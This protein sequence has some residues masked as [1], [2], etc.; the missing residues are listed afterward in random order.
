MLAAAFENWIRTLRE[1]DFDDTFLELLRAAGFYDLHFTHGQ[2][3]FGKD[4]IAKLRGAP[5]VQYAF[6]SKA[7]D[8]GGSDW[9]RRTAG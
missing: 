9:D 1:R 6:Q 4:V 8:I 7:G 5:P 2:Y 3:E